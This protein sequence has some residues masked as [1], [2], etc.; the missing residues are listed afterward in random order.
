M[1]RTT[2]GAEVETTVTVSGAEAVDFLTLD[3]S[4]TVPANTDNVTIARPPDGFIYELVTVRLVADG[5]SSA[6]S[7]GHGWALES[8]SLDTV[9]LKFSSAPTDFVAYNTSTV[10]KAT[11]R[12]TPSDPT[13]Q[14]LLL[15]GLRFDSTDGLAIRY[16]NSTNADQTQTRNIE[17]WVRQIQVAE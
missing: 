15:R 4:S 7:G 9:V 8:E 10:S 14:S 13:A 12:S 6:T 17:A 11:S 3:Q 2:L 1:V 16:F 5:V